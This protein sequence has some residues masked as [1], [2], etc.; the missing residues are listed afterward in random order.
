M[1]MWDGEENEWRV[2]VDLEWVNL[3]IPGVPY[4]NNKGWLLVCGPIPGHYGNEIAAAKKTRRISASH[5]SQT[6][7]FISA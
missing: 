2:V 3:K 5:T 7:L 6:R 4:S 1:A